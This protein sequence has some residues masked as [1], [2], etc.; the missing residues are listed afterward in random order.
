MRRIALLVPMLFVLLVTS[1][2]ALA[3]ASKTHVT[4]TETTVSESPPQR[5]W[6]SGEV[7]H[8]RGV[9]ERTAVAGDLAG[10]ITAVLNGNV[11]LHTGAGAVFGPFTLVTSHVTWSGSFRGDP[12]GSGTFIAQGTD[13]SKIHG[14]FVPTGPDTLEAEAVILSPKG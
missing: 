3:R 10:S 14:S 13:G 8:F 1:H 7:L 12:S 11:N 9:V 4:F 6:F 2:P 5:E